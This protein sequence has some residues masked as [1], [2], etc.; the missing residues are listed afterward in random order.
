M[1]D[2]GSR[3]MRHHLGADAA[4]PCCSDCGRRPLPGELL[5][6]FDSG[7]TLCTL[8]VGALTPDARN[9]VRSERIHVASRP[10][11]VLRRAA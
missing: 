6:V 5:H 2:L 1:A 4:A 7:R 10:L 11:A 3:L 9:P 8:C